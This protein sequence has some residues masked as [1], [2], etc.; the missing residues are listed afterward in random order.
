MSIGHLIRQ[1]QDL[2]TA[3][4]ECFDADLARALDELCARLGGDLDGPQQLVIEDPVFVQ[5][6]ILDW[7][8]VLG[9]RLAARNRAADER[10]VRRVALNLRRRTGDELAVALAMSALASPLVALG[11]LEEAVALR[12]QAADD[13][14]RIAKRRDGVWHEAVSEAERLTE[15]LLVR[16]DRPLA[17]L[18]VADRLVEELESQPRRGEPYARAL[19]LRARMLSATGDHA[20]AVTAAERAVELFRALRD[21]REIARTLT[22]LSD[23]QHLS[24]DLTAALDTSREALHAAQQDPA[25][26]VTLS[27]TWGDL[28]VRHSN[29]GGWAEARRCLD[30]ALALDQ[31]GS[32][33]RALHLRILS[34]VLTRLGE[35]EQALDA[36]L[37]A[38]DIYR[39]LAADDPDRYLPD[40]ATGLT[41]LGARYADAGRGPKAVYVTE[42]SV[43]HYRELAERDDCRTADLAQAYGCLA[44]RLAEIGQPARA[45]EEGQRCA[46]LYRQTGDPRLADALRTLGTYLHD[47]GDYPAATA[48][49]AEAIDL[50]RAAGNLPRLA[51]VLYNAGVTARVAG[52]VEDAVD[53]ARE[54][55]EIYQRLYD[56]EDAGWALDLA[57]ALRFLG[58]TWEEAGR[59]EH[60]I[61]AM[62]RAVSLLERAYRP[63]DV[64]RGEELAWTLHH[65]S[66]YHEVEERLDRSLTLMRRSVSLYGELLQLDPDR[67]RGRLASAWVSLSVYLWRTNQLDECRQTL[68][69]A[70]DLYRETGDRGGLAHALRMLGNCTAEQGGEGYEAALAMLHEALEI[71]EELALHEPEPYLPK[72]AL[73]LDSLAER[74]REQGD[75]IGYR[76]A[77]HYI[78][79]AAD[80][81]ARLGDTEQLIGSLH[82]RLFLLTCLGRDTEPTVE[83]LI[84][85]QG[86]L[87]RTVRT[88]NDVAQ[89][90]LAAGLLDEAHRQLDRATALWEIHVI[91]EPVAD[92]MPYAHVL[93]SMATLLGRLGR[94][95]E[96][97]AAQAAVVEIF[98]ERAQADPD[99][100]LGALAVVLDRLAGYLRDAGREQDAL[101]YQRRCVQIV[102]Q[103]AAHDPS[104]RPSLVTALEHL[105]DLLSGLGHADAGAVLD[106]AAT[107]RAALPADE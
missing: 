2:A 56:E 14:I 48:A 100:F 99:R 65:L 104:H 3:Q 12:H 94:P 17:A 61:T 76:K 7:L 98:E 81:W 73:T 42:E 46:E 97:A 15:L 57:D 47:A 96:A 75:H 95:G 93:D 51:Q 74:L 80:I 19:R 66:R 55:V 16:L 21:P 67:F 72:L 62:E 32:D 85:L 103:R 105:G 35:P 6:E 91:Q 26:R 106:R 107:L 83:R 90:L 28:A 44:E 41:D 30:E 53:H 88:L 37:E 18:R 40:L 86:D 54:S 68:R 22:M 25:D 58:R 84:E 78:D 77:L 8:D 102:E 89:E 23:I 9:R 29:L 63:G 36:M 24:G 70:V 52:R 69:M 10:D 82:R 45:A 59:F 64:E 1:Y 50:Y 27:L 39:D 13:M 101:P 5:V 31:P 60:A 38:V 43:K 79:R 33:L 71:L 20:A 11:E 92:P 34:E 49:M 4:P 87:A